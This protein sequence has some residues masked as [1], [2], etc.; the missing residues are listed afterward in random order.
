MRPLSRISK[1]ERE[2]AADAGRGM[3]PLALKLAKMPPSIVKSRAP[4]AA[5]CEI[6]VDVWMVLLAKMLVGAVAPATAR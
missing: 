4:K 6:S 1:A 2:G 5:P 3:R